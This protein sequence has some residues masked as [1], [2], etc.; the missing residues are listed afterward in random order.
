MQPSLFTRLTAA[1]EELRTVKERLAEIVD[2]IAELK[3]SEDATLLAHATTVE[4]DR[5][6]TGIGGLLA[7]ARV[8]AY[9][10]LRWL[11]TTLV[12]TGDSL[13]SRVSTDDLSFWKEMGRTAIAGV[14]LLAIFAIGVYQ[15]VKHS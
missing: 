7:R 1:E 3:A 14:V 8:T 4:P 11:G 13:R 2:V 6:P 5:R 15:L 9:N 10:G 12:D